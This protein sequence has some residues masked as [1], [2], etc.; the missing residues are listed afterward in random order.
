MSMD[1]TKN[2]ENIALLLKEISVNEQHL[3]IVKNKI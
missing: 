3:L 2:K 1:N